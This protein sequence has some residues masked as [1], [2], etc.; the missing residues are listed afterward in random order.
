MPQLKAIPHAVLEDEEAEVVMD[1][2][3]RDWSPVV[4][5]LKRGASLFL[6]DEDIRPSDIK[7]LQMLFGR[8]REAWGF[9]FHSRKAERNGE[10]GRILWA[11]N[12]R[13]AK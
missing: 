7:Y 13:K 11:E 12:L 2:A 9:R 10:T 5:H 3:R 8:M 4:A 1:T 6:K